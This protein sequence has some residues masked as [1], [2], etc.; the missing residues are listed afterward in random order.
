MPMLIASILGLFIGLTKPVQ[1]ALIGHNVRDGDFSGSWR[2]LG[3]GLTMLGMSFAVV[4]I[5][6]DGM[7]TRAGEKKACVSPHY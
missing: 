2:S 4:D 5:L 1:H 6:A 3:F 7:G